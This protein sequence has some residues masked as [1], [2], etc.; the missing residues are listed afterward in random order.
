MT[1]L[2]IAD[3]R[4]LTRV[5]AIEGDTVTLREGAGNFIADHPYMATMAAGY[6]VNKAI[7]KARGTSTVDVVTNTFKF[8]ARTPQERRIQKQLV[9]TLV[10]SKHYTLLRR[11]TEGDATVWVLKRQPR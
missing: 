5:L 3:I 10:D 11:T 1:D 2:T 7:K 6:L 8:Y 9:D 4:V